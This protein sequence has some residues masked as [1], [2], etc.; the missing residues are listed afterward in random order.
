MEK[1]IKILHISPDHQVIYFIIMNGCTIRSFIP[2][3]QAINLL[4]KERFDLI[5]SEP[6]KLA[7]LTPHSACEA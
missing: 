4:K 7:I 6:Q 1:Q 5:L 2:I 3:E